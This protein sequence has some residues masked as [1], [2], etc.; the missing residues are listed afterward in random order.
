MA[1]IH[2][3]VKKAGVT[4]REGD[5]DGETGVLSGFMT[6]MPVV[7]PETQAFFAI[8]RAISAYLSEFGLDGLEFNAT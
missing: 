2:Y 5:Y 6:P 4:H 7:V 8:L 3:E 1:S